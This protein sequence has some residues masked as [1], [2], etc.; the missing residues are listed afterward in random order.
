MKLKVLIE[1]LAKKAGVDLTTDEFK[2]IT[3]PDLD[4]DDSIAGSIDKGLLNI[5]AAKNNFDVRKALKAEALNGVDKKVADLLEE[6]GIES[7]DDVKN[8]PNTYEKIA[9]LA[10]AI[11]ATEEKKSK[12]T[13]KVDKEG[14]DTQIKELQRQLK[15][16]KDSSILKETDFKST[17]E[18]DLTNY[19]IQTILMGKDYALPKEMA[20]KLKLSTAKSAIDEALQQKGYKITRT[21]TG[22]LAIV[23]KDGT[24]AFSETH[25]PV[26]INQF[27]DGALAQNKLLKVNDQAPPGPGNNQQTVFTGNGQSAPAPQYQQGI[28]QLEAMIAEAQKS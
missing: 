8:E 3:L 23:K 25:E 1:K 22:A 6:L 27:L 28:S 4:I 26:E 11:K 19:E 16:A 18:T 20:T 7:A 17:R 15:E 14:Y 9:K 13:G 5:D 12:S 2:A 24:P 10:A 21:E